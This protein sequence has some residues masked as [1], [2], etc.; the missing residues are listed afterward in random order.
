MSHRCPRCASSGPFYDS[1]PA[2]GY[3]IPCQKAVTRAR[4]ARQHATI[5][6]TAA[7]RRWQ[8]LLA[9]PPEAR[10]RR[11]HKRLLDAAAP[12]GKKVCA[13]CWLTKWPTAFPP[14]K[15]R[16]GRDYYCRGCRRF[17]DHAR[18]HAARKK[19]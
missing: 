8:R 18:H 11:Q 9:T 16:D 17:L 6:A 19:T 12:P 4:Y 2:R 5:N 15:T 3:C 7:A 1:Q 14:A 13:Y 10:T